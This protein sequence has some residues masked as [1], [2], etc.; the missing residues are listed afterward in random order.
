MS[1]L[2][3]LTDEVR[4]GSITV[5]NR[6]ALA[7][8]TNKQSH[9]DGTLS[10]EE[11]HWLV[12]RAEGGFGLIATCAANVLPG[13]KTWE[14]ELGIYADSHIPGLTRLASALHEAGSA[15]VV[16]IFHGGYRSPSSISGQ[17][18]V[19]CTSFTIDAEGFEQPRELSTDEVEATIQAYVEAAVRA[20][21]AGFDG[22]EIHGAHTYLISQFL[23]KE[24]N[25][26][27]DRYGGT[28]EN[29]YR[30]LSEIICG[31][32]SAC[33][34]DFVVGVR[35]SPGVPMP[36]A[37]MSLA[38]TLEITPWMVADGVDFIHLSLKEAA[39]TDQNDERSGAA[40]I[41][42]VRAI[43]PDSVALLAAG[44]IVT[45]ADVERTRVHGADMVAVAR[46]AIGNA[47]WPEIV[48]AGDPPALPPHSEEHLRDEGLSP[49]FVEYMRRWPGFVEGGA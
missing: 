3:T 30:F 44:G 38:E 24:Y 27:G 11:L 2:H 34:P 36:H 1:R 4:I 28:L 23:S 29:R 5:R 6:A 31:V 13:G 12:R 49:R 37:G 43:I 40:A 8:M 7:A 39:G 45:R 42:G 46:A 16:Q 32:R 19:S 18:P 20:K 22:V 10:D 21:T 35:V 33:G 14:G 41:P 26:R 15:A 48:S 47:R 9:D 17:Q 25:T